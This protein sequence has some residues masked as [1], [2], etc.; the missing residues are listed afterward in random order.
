MSTVIEL[1][2]LAWELQGKNIDMDKYLEVTLSHIMNALVSLVVLSGNLSVL[3]FYHA[4]YSALWKFVDMSLNKSPDG[5]NVMMNT[6][7]GNITLNLFHTRG[8]T[9][10]SRWED[11]LIIL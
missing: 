5:R 10:I 7:H 8:N 1:G 11:H 9:S 6:L 2:S 3:L 4:R